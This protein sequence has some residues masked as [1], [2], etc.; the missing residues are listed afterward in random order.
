[1]RP[2]FILEEM[3]Y[4]FFKSEKKQIYTKTLKC[5][6]V[7]FFHEIQ[8]HDLSQIKSLGAFLLTSKETNS[9]SSLKR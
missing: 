7:L 1:M 4:N 6:F 5:R 3:K 2:Q 8:G 9:G